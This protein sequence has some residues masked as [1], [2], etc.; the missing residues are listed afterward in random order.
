MDTATTVIAPAPSS[1]KKRAPEF[2]AT[3]EPAAKVARVEEPVPDLPLPALDPAPAPAS[4]PRRPLEL[5]QAL[6]KEA[7]VKR[8]AA[9]ERLKEATIEN[10]VANEYVA[11]LLEEMAPYQVCGLPVP[12]PVNTE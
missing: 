6:H 10:S 1:P 11:A 5:L 2:D 8:D 12:A 3:E 7:C 4:A 9:Y